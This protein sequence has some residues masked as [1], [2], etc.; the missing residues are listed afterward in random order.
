MNTQI[1]LIQPLDIL[2]LR[3]NK[4]FGDTGEHGASSMPPSPS[5]L[6]G[7]LRSFWLAEL[8]CD[9]QKFKS[10]KAQ[11][12]AEPIRSQLGT[13]S[14]PCGFRLAHSG[15]A[16]RVNAQYERVFPIP[17]DLV[18]QKD[19]KDAKEPTI[20]A[21]KPTRLPDGLLSQ[22][23]E[24][25]QVPMLQAP[26][27]K[28]ETQYWLDEAGYHLY[29]HGRAKEISI[30]NLVKV[31]EL[32][33]KDYRLGI[34]LD[35]DKRTAAEGQLYT[36]E[37]IALCEGVQ[38]VAEIQGAPEFPKKGN[39]R[40]G[41]DGRGAGFEAGT[42]KPL[43]SIQAKNGKIKLILTSPAI[44]AGGWKLPSQDEQGRI[45]FAGGSARVVTASVPRHQ[46]ISGWNL[47]EW[48]PKPAERVVPTSSV[49]W[50]EDVQCDAAAS[51][52]A[53]LQ[54]LLLSDIDPQR[55][56]EGYNAGVLAAW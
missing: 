11:D 28:P 2:L 22:M 12:F 32:W 36:T 3:G 7:A 38:L 54:E 33:K 34:A 40:L 17:T 50:L 47:A 24:G 26:A 27:G 39:L 1:R 18:I 49:Y 5:V 48:K 41:G 21:L 31:S 53:A 35:S 19:S 20:Y 45:Q 56:A 13:P 37:A 9:L 43:P 46:V 25:Q 16:R 8:G 14:E 51:L 55:R 10:A 23:A 30:K 4:S 15:L 6:A 44:F 52:Q 42:L 29:L